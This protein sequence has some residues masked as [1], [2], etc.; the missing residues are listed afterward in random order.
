MRKL[1][2]AAM[3]L[4]TA[5]LPGCTSTAEKNVSEFGASLGSGFSRSN[6]TLGTGRRVD[7]YGGSTSPVLPTIGAPGFGK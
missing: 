7:V 2:I 4:G 3:V 6:D 1:I 5:A